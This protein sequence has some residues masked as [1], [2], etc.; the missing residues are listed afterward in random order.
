MCRQNENIRTIRVFDKKE[1]Q[2]GFEK[3]EKRH[4]RHY[5][6]KLLNKN[7][8]WKWEYYE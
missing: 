3:I 2:I 5:I 8:T 7:Y 6:I 4:D 1:K